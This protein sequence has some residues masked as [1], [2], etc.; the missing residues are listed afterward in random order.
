M[1]FI[2]IHG[3]Y[4]NPRENWFPW[5]QEE[6]EKLKHNVFVPQFP[7]P[8]G[9]SL[10]NWIDKMHNYDLF[11]DSGLILV[12]HSIGATFI[13]KKLE[14]METP[15][16]AAFLVAGVADNINNKKFDDINKSFFA[17]GFNWDKIKK[18]AKRFYVY[19]SDND[20]F[21]PLEHAK[22]IAD[23]LGVKLTLVKGAGHFSEKSGYSNFPLLLEDI[24][25]ELK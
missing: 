18:N 6:L 17:N 15:I 25:K 22:K 20:P 7:T 23:G 12:G 2:I 10:E 21:V 11:F 9:Q 14:I 4:G 5:L 19:H 3:A 8:E 16:K 24:K 13:L 1:N